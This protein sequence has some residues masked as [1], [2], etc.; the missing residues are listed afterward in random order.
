M[1][2]G[3][4]VERRRVEGRWGETA[5]GEGE[6]KEQ[7]GFARKDGEGSWGKGQREREGGQRGQ[8]GEGVINEWRAVGSKE[9]KGEMERVRACEGEKDRV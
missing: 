8:E 2:E 3:S 4:R 5:R 9:E 7:E 6:V 1:M